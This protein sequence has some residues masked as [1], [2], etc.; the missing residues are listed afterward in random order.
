MAVGIHHT[1]FQAPRIMRLH[2]D[3][4]RNR[5]ED[6]VVHMVGFRL[7]TGVLRKQQLKLVDQPL[8]QLPVS[9]FMGK[10]KT[11]EPGTDIRISDLRSRLMDSERTSVLRIGI[12][13][14]PTGK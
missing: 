7:Q 8:L 10:P 5:S 1:Q 13:N 6:I 11:S 4:Q 2:V 12:G 14:K 9:N 3:L